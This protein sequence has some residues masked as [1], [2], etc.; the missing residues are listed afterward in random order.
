MD[1]ALS[2]GVPVL[3]DTEDV[4]EVSSETSALLDYPLQAESASDRAKAG[5]RKN[6]IFFMSKK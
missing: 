6:A 3:A 4:P 1:E 5:R 2:A